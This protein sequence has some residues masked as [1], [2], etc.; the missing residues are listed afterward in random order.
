MVMGE[1][2]S[3]AFAQIR[4]PGA[5]LT[6]PSSQSTS[7]PSTAALR[8]CGSKSSVSYSGACSNPVL[9]LVFVLSLLGLFGVDLDAR[10]F[11][12]VPRLPKH[13][14]ERHCDSASDNSSDGGKIIYFSVSRSGTA[15]SIAHSHMSSRKVKKKKKQLPLPRLAR[16]PSRQDQ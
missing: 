10:A 7:P 14:H 12:H 5:S 15:P 4:P 16:R 1:T 2:S 8:H 11:H 6:T 13:G 9:P 3:R